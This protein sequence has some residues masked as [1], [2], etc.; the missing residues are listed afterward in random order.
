MEISI[1]ILAA[2][3]FTG[4]R[5]KVSGRPLEICKDP[6]EQQDQPEAMAKVAAM[7]EQLHRQVRHLDLRE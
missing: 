5:R 4:R 6:S 2:W 1:L 3:F 7:G